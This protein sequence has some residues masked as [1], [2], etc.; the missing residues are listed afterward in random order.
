[1]SGGRAAA[2]A[3]AL[4]LA[5]TAGAECA[6]ESSSTPESG[7]NAGDLFEELAPIHQTVH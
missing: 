2:I 4:A 1:L 6:P 5:A 7:R 3:L